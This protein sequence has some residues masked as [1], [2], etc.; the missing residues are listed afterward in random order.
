MTCF[1]WVGANLKSTYINLDINIIY[2]I[3]YNGD[4]AILPYP[5]S[6]REPPMA[7]FISN[8]NNGV[9][10]IISADDAKLCGTIR[11]VGGN[12]L[13]AGVRVFSFTDKEHLARSSHLKRVYV[14]DMEFLRVLLEG[15]TVSPLADCRNSGWDGYVP[16]SNQDYND[17]TYLTTVQDVV[18]KFKLSRRD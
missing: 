2:D 16:Y 7:A 8:R 18:E 3:L 17:P 11:A 10:A 14:G 1:G 15:H 4:W 12:P 13:L 6:A 5:T 9:T